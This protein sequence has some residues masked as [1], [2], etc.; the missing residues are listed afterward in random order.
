MSKDE[1]FDVE[2]CRLAALELAGWTLQMMMRIE[3]KTDDPAERWQALKRGLR[4]VRTQPPPV[5]S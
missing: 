4:A 5:K 1:E 2:L 3:Q